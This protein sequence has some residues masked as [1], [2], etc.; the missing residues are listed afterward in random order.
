MSKYSEAA[1]Q[2]TEP[3]FYVRNEGERLLRA[4]GSELA[5]LRSYGWIR[6]TRAG[7]LRSAL[8]G[9]PVEELFASHWETCS[10]TE[11]QQYALRVF[12]KHRLDAPV[13]S[14]K[15]RLNAFMASH[16][17]GVGRQPVPHGPDRRYIR[18]GI[19]KEAQELRV[20]QLELPDDSCEEALDRWIAQA[21]EGYEQEQAR[22]DG[23]QQRAS[24]FLGATGLTTTAVLVN[25]GVLYGSEALDS[26]GV[27]IVIGLLLTLATIAL[28]VAGYM[29]LEATMS[30]FDRARPNSPWQI[31][32]RAKLDRAEEQRYLLAATLLTVQRA[33]AVGDWKIRYMK[34]ARFWFALAILFIVLASTGL[35]IAALFS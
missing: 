32:W 34:W 21:R 1:R 13:L 9:E 17:L 28:A 22:I 5:Y 20:G 10:E 6:V 4:H 18:R 30:T 8:E 31:A 14:R 12:N 29:A 24:F 16:D 27:R 25:S 33:E 19:Q 35:L 3:Q 15:Q 26:F 7:R 2:G 23:I 11:A